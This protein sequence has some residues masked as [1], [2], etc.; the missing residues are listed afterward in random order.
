MIGRQHGRGFRYRARVSFLIENGMPE[1]EANA[2]VDHRKHGASA[3]QRKYRA[4]VDIALLSMAIA[5]PYRN[6]RRPA[7]PFAGWFLDHELV[8]RS[9]PVAG[10]RQQGETL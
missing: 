2:L 7:F 1:A 10:S 6:E 4:S 8:E 9:L 3:D 5:H